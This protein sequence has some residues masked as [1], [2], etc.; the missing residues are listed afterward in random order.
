[1]ATLS[2][3]AAP[4]DT[5]PV[6]LGGGAVWGV[7]AVAFEKA[8][9]LGIALYLPRHLGLADYGRYALLVSYLGFFQVLPDASLESVLVARLAG[10]RSG[11]LALAGRGAVV[12]LAV[13]LAGAVVGLAVL[14]VVTRDRTLVQAG[15]IGAVGLVAVA[16]TPYRALLRGRL[17]MTRYLALI[18]AQGVLAVILLVAVVHEGG[19]LAPVL[20]AVSGA[21]LAGAILGRLLVGRGA[22]LQRD[23]MLG[24]A[25]VAEAWPL[26][27]TSLA[28]LGAQQVLLLVLLRE[29][30]P[31]AMGLFGGASRLVDAIGLLPAAIMLTVLPTLALAHR[32][33]GGAARAAA[34]AARLLVIV[35]LPPAAALGLWPEPVLVRLL[36]SPFAAA[37]P[38][39]RVLAASA[40]VGATGTLLT[41][42]LLVV[43]LQRLLLR[44]SALAGGLMVALA[45]ALVPPAGAMGAAV[46]MVFVMLVGQLALAALPASAPVVRPVLRVALAPLALG[47]L[48]AAAIAALGASFVPG[49]A[50]LVVGYAAILL[51]TRT[52]TR[53][54]LGRWLKV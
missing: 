52:V 6:G 37:A 54:E 39:L 32:A 28:L 26:A 20:G 4:A 10:A 43:G 27:G 46:T 29:H 53:A 16:A 25:L 50:L 35:V 5:P 24:R 21:Q 45:F 36:G 3:A 49:L 17:A 47:L 9:V 12:R 48:V 38:L 41:S 23:A 22:V 31:A 51:A 2:G 30:G 18:A 15:A 7:L 11:D 40:I 14:A 33:P 34:E 44:V 19:G 13:S 42:L 1:V 8:V